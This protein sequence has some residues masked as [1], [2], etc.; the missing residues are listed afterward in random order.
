[1][2]LEGHEQDAAKTN[3]RQL[4]TYRILKD[5][6]QYVFNHNTYSRTEGFASSA[7]ELRKNKNTTTPKGKFERQFKALVREQ[8]AGS[9]PGAAAKYIFAAMAYSEKKKL[10]LSL[11]A[12][13][14]KTNADM[15]KLLQRWKSEAL[16]ERP[17]PKR[18]PSRELER[19]SR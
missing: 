3:R 1:M 2:V 9:S 5:D 15:D 18:S 12:M 6:I 8:G 17:L 16:R 19:N 13:G 10:N 11:N 14:V 4:L 7:P